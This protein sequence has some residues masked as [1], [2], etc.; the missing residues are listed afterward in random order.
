MGLLNALFGKAESKAAA[1]VP[2]NKTI[3]IDDKEPLKTFATSAVRVGSQDPQVIQDELVK[4]GKQR[5]A[6]YSF[7]QEAAAAV[8][9]RINELRMVLLDAKFP[10]IS[11]DFFKWRR[12]S[13][14]WPVFSFFKIGDKGLTCKIRVEVNIWDSWATASKK[15]TTPD[16]RFVRSDKPPSEGS[17]SV[18]SYFEDVFEKL[19]KEAQK[20]HAKDGRE[21]FQ[22]EANFHGVIPTA[23]KAKIQEAMTLTGFNDILI[24][25]EADWRLQRFPG[26]DPLV[27]GINSRTGTAWL[28]DAFDVTPVENYLK[29]EF[30][31]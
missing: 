26:L 13:D 9:V 19:E 8:D 2:E 22:L 1:P 15:F 25:A 4:L 5:N 7:E 12:K 10:R 27:I 17:Y 11:L 30:A 23:N 24:V 18:E 21:I 20:N 31:S 29:S 14:G 3:E 28:I 16:I 6:L